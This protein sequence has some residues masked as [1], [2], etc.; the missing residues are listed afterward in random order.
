MANSFE[1]IWICL[2]EVFFC[3]EG[4]WV[5]VLKILIDYLAFCGGLLLLHQLSLLEVD[6][7]VA[8]YQVWHIMG[9]LGLLVLVCLLCTNVSIDG[10]QHVFLWESSLLLCPVFQTGV[11]WICC[12]LSGMSWMTSILLV[13]HQHWYIWEQLGKCMQWHDI[14][15][16]T[17]V[18]LALESRKFVWSNL[19]RHQDSCKGFG[20]WVYLNIR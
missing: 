16:C 18:D 9:V 4:W 15:T 17:S 11:F 12:K 7:T 10:L 20:C 5:G 13:N 14:T 2:D 19:S 3:I 6:C 8:Q 1:S